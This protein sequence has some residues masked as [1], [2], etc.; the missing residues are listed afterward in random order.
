ML[1]AIDSDS[2]NPAHP[3][4]QP[5]SSDGESPESFEVASS[6]GTPSTL[7]GEFESGT[8]AM[9]EGEIVNSVPEMDLGKAKPINAIPVRASKDGG[10]IQ[11]V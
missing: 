6:L 4:L 9:I 5:E 3:I 7:G 11:R 10:S 1:D 8:A 2:I